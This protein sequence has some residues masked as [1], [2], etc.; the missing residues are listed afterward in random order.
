[1]LAVNS[2]QLTGVKW[3]LERGLTDE[4]KKA[5]ESAYEGGLTSVHVCSSRQLRSARIEE[6]VLT[7]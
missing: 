1:M 3:L 2:V 4:Q 6:L 7:I 5:L